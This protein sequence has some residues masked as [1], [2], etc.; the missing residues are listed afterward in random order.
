MDIQKKIPIEI[1]N[2]IL[3]YVGDI[4]KLVVYIYYDPFT[5]HENYK[6]NFASDFLWNLKSLMLM[7]RLYPIYV[8]PRD[9]NNIQLYDYGLKHYE[10]L[11]RNNISF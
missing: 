7:K 6:I 4:N 8:E 10:N 11:L 2:I 1:V 5:C 9:F 3:T